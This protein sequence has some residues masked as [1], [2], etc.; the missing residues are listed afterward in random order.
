MMGTT[1]DEP[2]AAFG[3]GPT[4]EL[5]AIIEKRECFTYKFKL[6]FVPVLL[7]NVL[8]SKIGRSYV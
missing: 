3:V 7:L 2:T 4:L 5:Y 6:S 1:L 8:L